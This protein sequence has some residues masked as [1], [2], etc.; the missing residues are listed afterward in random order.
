MVAAGASSRMSG[1][2]KMTIPIVGRPLLAWSLATFV[3]MPPIDRVVVV[4]PPDRVDEFRAADW[5]PDAAIVVGGGKRRQESVAAG[6]AAL[7]A[8]GT[9]DER[10]VLV[11]DGARPVVP[12]QTTIRVIEAA[13]A[14]G[15]AI[16]VLPVVDTLKAIDGDLVAR[17]V[18]RTGLGFAQTPQGVQLG[19]LRRAY[20]RFPPDGPQTFTD[21]AALLEACTIPVRVVPGQADN[22]KVT[23]ATDL[24]RAAAAL[25][26]DRTRVGYGEDSH[27]F[28]PGAPLVLGG[29]QFP[30]APRLSGHSDGDVVLHAVAVALL[31]AAGLP[32]LGELFPADGRTPVGIDS[33][34]LLS[35]VVD[36][37]HGAQF[38]PVRIDVTIVAGRPR[39]GD[40]LD[41]VQAR[42]AELV[43]I[44]RDEVAIKASSG[45]LA[46]LEGAGRGISARA[47]TTLEPAW[48]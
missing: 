38:R 42:V 22:I 16:P 21:E 48:W 24:D 4:V 19:V 40:R 32:D 27:P 46:G 8:A 45:N 20:G 10:V 17:T 26:V 3:D 12:R 29:V 1:H 13:T 15:A 5:I 7:E 14:G 37:V 43:R 11:H 47:V 41:E 23:V 35:D 25:H 33:A 31:G 18:D 34:E 30:G 28:G 6:V 44:N 9:P 2:D 36:R 39:L